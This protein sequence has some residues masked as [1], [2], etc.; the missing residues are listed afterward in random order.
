[1][2]ERSDMDKLTKIKKREKK[3]KNPRTKIVNLKRAFKEF[4]KDEKIKSF[5]KKQK[6]KIEAEKVGKEYTNTLRSIVKYCNELQYNRHRYDDEDK[7]IHC[8]KIY[9]GNI[10]GIIDNMYFRVTK[11]NDE[12]TIETYMRRKL[13]VELKMNQ[14]IEE[15]YMYYKSIGFIKNDDIKYFALNTDSFVDIKHSIYESKDDIGVKF[16]TPQYRELKFE[17][18]YFLEEHTLKDIHF[19]NEEVIPTTK[20]IKCK[21]H[22][23]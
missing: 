11:D 20:N 13:P 3:Q 12:M 18:M 1:M 4:E 7:N 23:I 21:N 10:V 8:R 6:M 15:K 2:V 17:I 22:K 14:P 9:N 5:L 19:D 16:Y